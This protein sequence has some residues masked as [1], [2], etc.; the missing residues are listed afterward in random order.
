MGLRLLIVD[1][2]QMQ[3]DTLFTFLNFEEYGISDIQ[4]AANGV[5]CLE[6]ASWFHPHIIITDIEMPKMDG[7]K[8]V[9]ALHEAHSKA[10]VIIITCHKK[11]DYAKT[12]MDYGVSA[13]L[14]KPID[15]EEIRSVIQKVTD[16]ISNE[17]NVDKLF[18]QSLKQY[19][20]YMDEDSLAAFGTGED[21]DAPGIQNKITE[22]LNEGAPAETQLTGYFVAKEKKYV[23]NFILNALQTVLAERGISLYNVVWENEELCALTP[24]A[25]GNVETWLFQF[26]DAVARIIKSGEKRQSKYSKI[27]R[28]IK[29]IIDEHYSTIDSVEQIAE[30]LGISSSYAKRVFQKT[31]K[32]TVFDYLC[33]RRIEA[34]KALLLD[35]Y[36]KVYEIA[37]R[38]GYRSKAYFTETFKKHVGCTPSEY[39]ERELN[40]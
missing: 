39:R 33:E 19:G 32:K 31:D 14:L 37:D 27:S 11:F 4:T 6:I 30:E 3:I 24:L 12:A 2:N 23:C 35:P 40:T 5:M 7:L 13:F 8:I 1:D 29:N 17:K 18:H 16:E 10:K 26:V 25:S 22:I 34:A 38:V 28:D 9:Q 15:P 36:C 20:I 21:F